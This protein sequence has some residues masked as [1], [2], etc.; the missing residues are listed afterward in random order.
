MVASRDF[1]VIYESTH[2][3]LKLL[4]TRCCKSI[5]NLL[6]FAFG[7]HQFTKN[8]HVLIINKFEKLNWILR[9]LWYMKYNYCYKNVLNK[10]VCCIKF[11][12]YFSSKKTL[13][14]NLN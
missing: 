6:Y 8:I 11:A 9:T 7:T 10:M 12:C 4:K 14:Q 3:Y 13:E 1:L 2:R 5:K